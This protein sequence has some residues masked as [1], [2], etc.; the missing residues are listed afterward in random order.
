MSAACLAISSSLS[1]QVV[2][3]ASATAGLQWVSSRL[4]PVAVLAAEWAC[5]AEPNARAV[6]RRR[7]QP[8]DSDC[9][10]L[11]A[12]SALLDSRIAVVPS[13]QQQ[14]SV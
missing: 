2:L 8:G 9:A 14:R 4:V 5:R 3:I 6:V 7:V 10:S 11:Y 12:C 13:L 1:V